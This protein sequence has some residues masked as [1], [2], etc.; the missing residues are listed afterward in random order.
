MFRHYL[1]RSRID[2]VITVKEYRMGGGGKL[3]QKTKRTERKILKHTIALGG[4]AGKMMSMSTSHTL[5]A[6]RDEK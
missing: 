6:I 4:S 1:V 3:K 5:Q 2:I